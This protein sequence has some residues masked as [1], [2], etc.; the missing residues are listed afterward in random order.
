MMDW[1]ESLF[2]GSLAAGGIFLIIG[3]IGAIL[4]LVSVLLDGI[5]DVFDFGDGPLSLTTISAFASIF[6]F[7]AFA[8]I[9]AGLSVG[10]AA[11]VGALAGLLGGVGAWWLSRAIRRAE[12]TTALGADELV[13]SEASVVLGIPADGL[14]EVSLVRHGERIAFSATA[15]TAIPRGERVR[16]VQVLTATSV[17]VEPVTDSSPTPPA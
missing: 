2:D 1:I 5:F 17:R 16:I 9:G 7:A 3:V 10:S 4:L 15:S 13:G 8:A 12:T 11:F 14:G 6:G